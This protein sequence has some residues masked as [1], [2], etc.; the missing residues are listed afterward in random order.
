M[1]HLHLWLIYLSIH[2]TWCILA[3]AACLAEY[4]LQLCLKEMKLSCIMQSHPGSQSAAA[5]TAV[6]H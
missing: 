5:A 1:T 2:F 3:R 6:C 4:D